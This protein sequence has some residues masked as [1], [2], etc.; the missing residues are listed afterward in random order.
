MAISG[1][2][3][4][5]SI[6]GPHIEIYRL[7]SLKGALKL[8][9]HG[10]K[11]RRGVSIRKHIAELLNMKPRASYDDLDLGVAAAHRPGEAEGRHDGGPPAR[12]RAEGQG[13]RLRG[14]RRRGCRHLPTSLAEPL[15]ILTVY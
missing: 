5:T 7:L 8:E 1:D 6:T 10:I 12:N 14:A 15:D 3:G 13:L 9:S 2:A 4:G 11:M